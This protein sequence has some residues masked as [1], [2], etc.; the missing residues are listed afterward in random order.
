MAPG[1]VTPEDLLAY[2]TGDADA[3]TSAHVAACRVCAEQAASFR[4]ADQFLRSRLFRVDCPPSQALGELVLELLEPGEALTVRAHLALCPHCAGELA[5]LGAA[6]QGDPLADLA[7]RPGPLARIVARLRPASGPAVAMAGVRGGTASETR[8]YDV[9]GLVVALTA[10]AGR[11]QRWSLLGLVVDETDAELPENVPVRLLR[12]GAAIA[13]T[14]LNEWGNVTFSDL[15]AG[16]Y[17]LELVLNDRV[18]AV[19]GITIGVAS[20]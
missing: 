9:G 12:D 2:A 4:A 19:E 17:V 15:E 7:Q 3:R 14:P 1:S 10:E 6:L 18:I 13:E 5:T 20:R 8:T 11:G 16:A